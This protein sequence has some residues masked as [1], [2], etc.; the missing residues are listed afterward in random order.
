MEYD[1]SYCSQLNLSERSIMVTNIWTEIM[2]Q[3]REWNLEQTVGLL[4]FCG[5][6]YIEYVDYDIEGDDGVILNAESVAYLYEASSEME[7]RG[8]VMAHTQAK[9]LLQLKFEHELLARDEDGVK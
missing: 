5:S 2:M 3:F 6:N 4:L 8:V 1:L 7:I 9:V